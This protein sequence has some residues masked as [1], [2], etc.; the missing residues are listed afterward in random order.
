VDA[1]NIAVAAAMALANQVLVLNA[2]DALNTTTNTL[3]AGTAKRLKTQG[4]AIQKRASSTMLD[5]KVLKTAFDDVNS[6]IEDISTYR[7]NA[8]PV[9]AQNILELNASA[10]QGE[11]VMRKLE[12]GN[13]VV[14]DHNLTL[15]IA[16]QQKAA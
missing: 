11:K 4:A 2:V 16:L 7:R 13:K 9:M 5:T 8:L 10:E 6:A 1:L 12:Q 14:V 3:I 15:D